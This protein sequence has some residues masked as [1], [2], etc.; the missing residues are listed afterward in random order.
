MLSSA[1]Q[2]HF[3]ITATGKSSELGSGR[4]CTWQVRGQEYT[5]ILNVILYDSAG[6]KDLSDTLNKKP[7]ASIG[8]RQTIQVINDVEKNCAVMMAVTDTT[9]V[10]TQAT[11]GVDVDKACEMAL[12]LARVVEPKL[13]RG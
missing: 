3:G 11:V 2:A 12:E 1:E 5:S 7:I 13:P 8:N 10:A 9:R 4:L 6:L